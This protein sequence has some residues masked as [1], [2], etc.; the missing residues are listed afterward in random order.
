MDDE[1]YDEPKRVI[2]YE[3]ADFGGI[4]I[5]KKSLYSGK[6]KKYKNCIAQFAPGTKINDQYFCIVEALQYIYVRNF[7]TSVT[8]KQISLL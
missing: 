7:K 3:K 5:S 6:G 1:V 2:S 4:N 8:L